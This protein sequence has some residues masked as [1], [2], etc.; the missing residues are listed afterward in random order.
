MGEGET[1]PIRKL[2]AFELYLKGIYLSRLE[3][4]EALDEAV[5]CFEL[6]TKEDPAF[7]LAYSAAAEA[8]VRGAG[9]LFPS[10]EAFRRAKELA[11]LALEL[12]PNAS[13]AH[14]VLANLALRGALDWEIAEEEFR[15]AIALNPGDAE[16]HFGYSI[17]LA[18]LQRFEEAEEEL[19]ET[20][21]ANPLLTNAWDW[22]IELKYRSGDLEAATAFAEEMREQHPGSFGTRWWAGCC[23]WAMGRTAEAMKEWEELAGPA[24]PHGRVSRAILSALLGKSEDAARLVK[25]LERESKDRYVP[26]IWMADLYATLG[27]KE[28]SLQVLERDLRE[29]DRG[30]WWAY[31]HPQYDLLWADPRF[32]ALL[33]E[34]HLPTKR[35]ERPTATAPLDEERKAAQTASA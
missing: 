12:E 22:L 19:R 35:K 21:R 18:T 9:L 17:L 1:K 8:Y 7:S 27:E 2:A 14:R 23:Y 10:K 24:K 32:V 31:Q 5:R 29:G 16:A 11:H 25:E 30:L 26:L 28:K 20:I 34:Y 33:K 6:A 3:T 4:L 15:K 13:E